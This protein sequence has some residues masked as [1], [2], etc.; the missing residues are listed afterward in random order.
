[1]SSPNTPVL[2]IAA[3][4]SQGWLTKAPRPIAARWRCVLR[5]ASAPRV[6]S[7]FVVS[8]LRATRPPA[9]SRATFEAIG[10]GIML[11]GLGSRSV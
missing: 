3:S 9:V 10:I 6:H 1:M 11:A 4:S 2:R 7:N 8:K 5:C